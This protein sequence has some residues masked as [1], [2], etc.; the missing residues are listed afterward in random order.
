MINIKDH[1]TRYMFDPFAHL[2]PKRRKMIDGSWA[3]VFREHILT[4]LP[5]NL[6]A[7]HF[8][9]REGHPTKELYAMMGALLIQQML[10][11]SD[12]EAVSQFAFNIQWHYA[13]DITDN[14]DQSAY[15]SLKTIWN[16]R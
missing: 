3:G 12:E 13:L 4:E 2:G 9:S 1:K 11:L 16:M 15:V 5:V 6:L 7:K 14:S 8:P 10:D